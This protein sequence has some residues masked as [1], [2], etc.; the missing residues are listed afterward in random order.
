MSLF[1]SLFIDLVLFHFFTSRL[2][3]CIFALES[4]VDR[5]YFG[6]IIFD[7][8]GTF[9]VL[10]ERVEFVGVVDMR[11]SFPLDMEAL[12]NQLLSGHVP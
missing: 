5:P 6:D 11:V 10:Q 7:S 4:L 1:D 2:I 9:I 8:L 3:F 12:L